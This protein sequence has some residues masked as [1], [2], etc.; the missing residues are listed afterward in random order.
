MT[1]AAVLGD[2][3]GNID[4]FKAVL[5]DIE[6]EAIDKLLIVGDLVGYYYFADEV[7]DTLKSW[8]FELIQGNHD[9]L[10]AEISNWNNEM[11][12]A[13]RQK[14]GSALELATELLSDAEIAYLRDLPFRKKLILKNRQILLCHGSPWDRDEYIYPDAS[15]E[16]LKR[17]AKYQGDVVIMGHTHYPM[18]KVIN[19]TILLNPGSVGQP[20]NRQY[21][22]SWVILDS[23]D[24]DI[25]FRVASYRVEKLITEVSKRDPDV[26]YL[27]EILK[28]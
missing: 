2:I 8:R 12:R 9:G 23:D 13:Y 25:Q 11:R 5:D 26:S 18:L 14:Y 1:R 27:I 20:R 3:H 22:A 16:V 10:L 21:G 7:L 19:S 15:T 6:R 4:A 28:R 17:C 24:L